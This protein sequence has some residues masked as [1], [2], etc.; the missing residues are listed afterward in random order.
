MKKLLIKFLIILILLLL[1]IFISAHSYAITVSN[2]LSSNLLRLHVI[3]NSD[4]EE[5]QKLKLKVRNALLEYMSKNLSTVSSKDNAIN[6]VLQNK[7]E[8]TKIA[9]EIIKN[10]GFNYDVDISIENTYFPTKNYSNISLPAGYY[11]SV[12]VKIGSASG[13]NWWC[14]MFPPL[15]FID[16]SS[17]ILSDNSEEYLES[18]LSPNTLNLISESNDQSVSFKFKILEFFSSSN[19]FTAKK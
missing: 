16:S 7:E 4:S 12:R 2:E 18:S 13:K 11:D 14:V 10:E 9:E 3:A 8:L 19:I 1:Y 15:C 6:F 17:G 5:D